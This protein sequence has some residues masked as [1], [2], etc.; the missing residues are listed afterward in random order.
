MSAALLTKD[1]VLRMPEIGA[2]IPS[3]DIYADVP[4]DSLHDGELEDTPPPGQ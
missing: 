2:E 3:S 4:P 1:D